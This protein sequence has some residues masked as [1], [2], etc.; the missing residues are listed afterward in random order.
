MDSNEAGN[1]GRTILREVLR[2]VVEGGG[3]FLAG[4]RVRHRLRKRRAQTTT[5]I[6]GGG[7]V[8]VG[9]SHGE[10]RDSAP[11]HCVHCGR[12]VSRIRAFGCGDL[13]EAKKCLMLN[14]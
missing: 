13:D 9:E 3:I 7:S 10:T 14:G 2:L 6:T 1:T 4:L 11:T 12:S 5:P 8:H